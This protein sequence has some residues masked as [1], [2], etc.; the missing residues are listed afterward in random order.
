MKLFF[1]ILLA[2]GVVQSVSA[3]HVPSKERGDPTLRR[4]NNIDG[5]NLRAT[6]FNYGFA[7]RTGGGIPD[8]IP[9]EWPKNTKQHYIALIALWIG[10]EVKYKYNG[11]DT[12]LQIVDLP[13]YRTDPSTGK[14]WNMEPIRGYLRPETKSQIAKSSDK[15]TWPDTWP[16]KMGD[17]NDPGWAGSWNGYF[18]KDQFNADQEMFYKA[19]DDQYDRYPSFF[20]DSTDKSRKGMGIILD[21]RAMEWSQILV[22]DVLFILHSVKND[23]TT[24]MK[25]AGVTLWLADLVGGDGDSGD[26]LPFFDLLTDLAWMTDKD[27]KGNQD[28]GS[29]PVGVATIAYL[30]TPGNGTDNIDN[31]GD[32]EAGSP[33]VLSAMIAGEISGNGIDDNNNNLVDEDSTHIPFG[34]QVGVGFADNID[35]NGNGESN[36][37]VISA[38]MFNGEIA[39]NAIDDNKNGAIDE[40]NEDVGKAY[41]DGIDNNNTGET[42]SPVITQVMIDTAANH[43]KT[44][45]V[46]SSVTLYDVGA[47]DLGLPY[48]DGIDNNGD[49]R[50]D[51]GID[52]NIDEMVDELRDDF[53]DN[54]GDWNAVTDDVGLDGKGGTGDTGEGDGKP[55]SGAGTNF[56]G[57]PNIDKTDVSESDQIG[58]TNVQYK[59]AGTFPSF[60]STA[61]QLLWNMFMQPGSFYDPTKPL[62]STDNDLFVSA[63]FFP[64]KAGQTE[65]ISIAVVMGPDQ[66]KASANKNKAQQTYNEDYQFAKAPVPPVLTAVPGDGR[67]TLY[68]DSKSEDSYDSFLAALGR[69]GLDFEGYKIY[70]ATD[71]AFLD[72]L[73]I[74]DG[75]GNLT[76]KKPIAQFDK[77]NQVKGFHGIDI[78]GVQFYLGNDTGLKH[79]FVDSTVQNGQTY[80]YAIT[81]YDVGWEG[82]DIAPSESP[83]AINLT[84]TGG[85]ELG[86]N[87]VKVTPE[88]PV[89]GFV[90]SRANTLQHVSGSSTGIINLNIVDPRLV[91]NN[92][93]YR[94]TF[95][96]TTIKAQTQTQQDTF[97][98]KSFTLVNVTNAAQPDTIFADYRN[99]AGGVELPIVDGFRLSFTNETNVGFN[100]KLSRWSNSNVYRMTAQPW[101][102]VAR[103]NAKPSDY[104]IVFGEKGMDTSIYFQPASFYKM[105][106]IPVNFSVY[107]RTENKKIKFA[108]RDVVAPANPADSGI[109]TV[110][111]GVE[112]SDLIAFFER[113]LNDSLVLTWRF[114]LIYDSVRTNPSAGD[115]AFLVIKKPFLSEDVYEFVTVTQHQDP[116]KAKTDLNKIKVV[117][118]PYVAAASWEPKNPYSSGR[119][120][121]SIHFNHVPQVCTIR[122]Y[123][124]NGELVQTINHS[125]TLLDGSAEW[126]LLTRDNL[127]ASY[128]VYIYHIDA[129]GIGEKIGRFAIIK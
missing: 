3:Q 109:F 35:N 78:N 68:W 64:L 11:R 5:N 39:D 76:F 92:N 127:P 94:I 19:S 7:G 66:A 34:T 22:S 105:P 90:P 128:G 124:V 14:S 69:P 86:Q 93:K 10:G 27:G 118:N 46:N 99:F 20:P 60:G 42:G 107:N 63:G 112:N 2:I 43:N 61:D 101:N 50:I 31:D 129:P 110:A 52:E 83:I 75:Q 67:V 48:A 70:R 12:T 16:D 121:R 72:A 33:K 89:A 28:F 116:E 103:G 80:Y 84:P 120:P 59:A 126:N 58:L 25:R 122:I 15:K 85:V 104:I 65:R 113:D 49:G 4:K 114:N 119:G 21:V 98:T 108:F 73:K 6:I 51:E 26:D 77:A 40:G 71:P 79:E 97:K 38:A 47:E 37:P 36:S 29:T 91:K 115:T 54:D 87:V 17:L 45:V 95:K 1:I 125:S 57:E 81:G 88:A 111:S 117:P 41:K 32:G 106:S 9:F 24:D 18:G 82:G 62:A 55:T 123:T 30:E 13:T 100:D 23:G 56:P 74:T 44:F 96:D 102:I 53:V 8:E